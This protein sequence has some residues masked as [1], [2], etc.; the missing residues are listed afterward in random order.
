M[1]ILLLC[2]LWA[3]LNLPGIPASGAAFRGLWVD[4][5]GPGFFNSAQVKKLA[6]DCRKYNFNAVFVEMRRRGD[7]FYDSKYD[8][9]TT[10]ITTNFDA[11]AEIIKE[12]HNGTP[13]I[14]VHCWVVSHFVWAWDKPP[15]QPDHVFNKHP[16]YLTKDSLGQKI[17]G[18]GYYL[19]PGNPDANLTIYHMAKDI[20]GRYDIDGLHW[21][22]CRYPTPDSGYNEVAIKR[23][24]EEFGLSGQPAPKDHRFSDWRRRQVSDFL[25][26]VNADLWEIK[27]SLVISAAVFANLADAVNSRYTDWPAWT[28]RGTVD[29]CIPMDFSVHNENVFIPRAEV[30]LTNQGIRGIYIGV[31][32]YANNIQN[33]L[34]QLEY[35]KS[36]G[37]DGTVIYSYR[38]PNSGIV[39][40]SGALSAIWEKF[41]PSWTPVPE[42]EWKK[43]DGI[44][45]GT[46]TSENGKPVYNAV[47]TLDGDAKNSERTG[48]RGDFAFFGVSPGAHSV[49]ARGKQVGRS[50]RLTASAGTVVNVSLIVP[51]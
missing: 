5:F 11:L 27:P 15:S 50:E 26:W 35:V 36:R 39:D 20:V 31:G 43:R 38:N 7:A 17:I 22:Y 18:K 8:P 14:Q 34:A 24:N 30:A 1:R 23:F 41:Q 12:C 28:Q 2:A 48:P 25:R 44:I 21:D 37:F 13:R 6:E 29:L 46:I 3:I 40:Q 45:K 19:D 16:E 33:T 32:A 10:I 9:R 47:V 42:L 49:S 4:A 51:P